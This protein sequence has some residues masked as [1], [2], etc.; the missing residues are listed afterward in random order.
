MCYAGLW[1]ASG[2]QPDQHILENERSSET[3]GGYSILAITGAMYLILSIAAA[4]VWCG[5]A[6]I[7]EGRDSGF[8]LFTR[9]RL[10]GVL[11]LATFLAL[12][13][14]SI[15][16]LFYSANEDV[17]L[18]IGAAA[19]LFITDV[20]RSNMKHTKTSRAFNICSLF[21][22]MFIVSLGLIDRTN[23]PSCDTKRRYRLMSSAKR[24]CPHSMLPL[25]DWFW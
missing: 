7:A 6:L 3:T 18:V 22:T 12:V 9:R 21:R 8:V 4:D 24:T 25:L 5:C 23:V 16:V 15:R 19:V 2:N 20:V 10:F 14:A 17:Q 1:Y 13:G 11:L